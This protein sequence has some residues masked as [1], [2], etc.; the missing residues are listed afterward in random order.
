MNYNFSNISKNDKK[1]FLMLSPDY[2]NVGDIA[3]S[4]AQEKILKKAYPDRY[5]IEI[6]MLNFYNYINNIKN[7]IND[8]D[9]I[10]IIGGGNMGSVYLEGEERR[11]A[12]IETFPN[13]TIISF[14]QSIDF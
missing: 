9:I 10:T 3:I 2:A 8:N 1:V 12:I 7:I 11:R 6:P 5:F 13:N 4:L 14:P